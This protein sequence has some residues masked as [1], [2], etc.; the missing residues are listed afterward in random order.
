MK[1][2]ILNKIKLALKDYFTYC[3]NESI[4]VVSLDKTELPFAYIIE[5]SSYPGCLLIAFAV[6]FPL[7]NTA[8]EI[9]LKIN[10]IK[11]VLITEHFY[12]SNSGSTFWGNEA[13]ERFHIDNVIDLETLEAA[14]EELN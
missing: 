3:K 6:N 11:D 7:A 4:I 2:P 10:K 8:A 13:L 12:I 9:A 14:S 1:L 5:D